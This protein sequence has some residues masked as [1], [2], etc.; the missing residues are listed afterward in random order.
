MYQSELFT[1]AFKGQQWIGG[2]CI[3]EVYTLAELPGYVLKRASRRDGTLNYLEWC[4]RMQS[5]GQ[6]MRGM[7]EI[8]FIVHT[9]HVEQACSG[10]SVTRQGYVVCMKRYSDHGFKSFGDAVDAI[11]QL[12]YMK[13]LVD[14]YEAFMQATFDMADCPAAGDLHGGNV[15]MEG[16]TYI[17][18]DPSARAYE[19]NNNPEEYT[20]Q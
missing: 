17:L 1:N 9:E 11:W 2:G 3:S 10:A 20:L 7:P 5:S 6:G 19:T 18:L 13:A 8:D 14:A 16:N 4:Q 12:D 15:M